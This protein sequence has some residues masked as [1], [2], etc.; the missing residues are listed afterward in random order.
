MFRAGFGERINDSRISS[1]ISLLEIWVDAG[2]ILDDDAMGARGGSR[3]IIIGSQVENEEFVGGGG[4]KCL[5]DLNV[6]G[7]SRGF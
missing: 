2:G 3:V 6:V 4:R 1:G 7:V 5:N